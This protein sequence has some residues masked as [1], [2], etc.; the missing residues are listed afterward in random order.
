MVVH[1]STIKD[2]LLHVNLQ[3]TECHG[4]AYDGAANMAGHLSGV[5]T[6]LQAEEPRMLFVHCMA[7]CL[8]LFLQD[9]AR[10]C[11]CVRDALDLTTELAS[12][13]HASPKRLALFQK[14]KHELAVGTPGLK[15]FCPTRWT[16]HTVALDA[17][18]KNYAVI[19]TELEQIGKECY[20]EP[21]R[22]ASGLLALMEKFTTFF[23][24]KLSH[25]VF[26]ATEQL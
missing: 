4:Q 9:C 5:A 24:L 6:H 18:L 10:N 17:V 16:V 2:I 7:H 26:S 3:L 8:N 11:C 25:L 21:S 13:I 22:K 20:G 23:G 15:P 19:C 14:L 1:A 12:L